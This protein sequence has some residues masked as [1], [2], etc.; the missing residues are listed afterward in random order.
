VESAFATEAAVHLLNQWTEFFQK[1][2]PACLIIT[3]LVKPFV[4]LQMFEEQSGS[5]G[6]QITN[7]LA[8]TAGVNFTGSCLFLVRQIFIM[9]DSAITASRTDITTV[10]FA[11]HPAKAIDK[12]HF[13]GLVIGEVAQPLMVDQ[14]LEDDF[15]LC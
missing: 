7:V 11:H 2:L 13:R 9:R 15:P 14:I 8:R 6:F 4:A 3:D 1:I 12:I 5:N 10:Q